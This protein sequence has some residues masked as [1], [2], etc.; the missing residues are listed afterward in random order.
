MATEQRESKTVKV[1]HSHFEWK[2]KTR[3]ENSKQRID[4]NSRISQDQFMSRGCEF[5]KKA[6]DSQLGSS[7][8]TGQ[9]S[10]IPPALRHFFSL[11]QTFA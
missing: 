5:A 9:V 6:S 1:N 4:L 10:I 11:R 7:F 2:G 8:V 3:K